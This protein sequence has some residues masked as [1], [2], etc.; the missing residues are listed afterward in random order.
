M[1]SRKSLKPGKAVRGLCALFLGVSAFAAS[2][3]YAGNPIIA[4]QGVND[5]HIHVFGDTAYLYASHDKSPHNT[6]FIMEDWQVWSSEDLVNWRLRSTLLP[7]QT[8]LRSQPDFASAWATDVAE[9]NGKYF[10]Y[11]SEGNHQTGVV[12]GDS[13]VGPWKDVLGAALL[14]KD[15]TPTDEYDPGLFAEADDRYIIFGVW[16]Y[17]MAKLGDDMMSLAETPRRIEIRGARGPYT[18]TSGTPFDGKLTDDKPFLH[19]QGD[20][21]YLSW[22]A[23]YATSKAL[24]GPYQYRGAVITEESFPTGL[25]APTWPTGPQ[26]GR[27]GS[28]FTWHGQTYFAY[29]D[30]SQSG[31]RYFRDTFISYV[32]YRDDGSI[33]PIR[34]D[35]TGVGEYNADHGPIEAEEFFAADAVTKRENAAASNGFDIVLDEGARALT[36]PN[37]RGLAGKDSAVFDIAGDS[38]APFTLSVWRKGAKAPIVEQGFD[39]ANRWRVP[40]GAL[41][42]T[43]SLIVKIERAGRNELALDRISF[44]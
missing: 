30:I 9:K 11:F 13:P 5:P 15:L 16:D 2:E 34:V 12:V 23:F 19:K 43:E 24:Y 17:Y 7:N 14:K 32:H 25:S 42:E 31:N 1:N 40:L 36:F 20:V 44:E 35:E 41:G 22:G 4:N 37:I 39:G 18:F 33:A 26:Q 28:F 10:W 21:Y 29:C 38:D 3:G 8:Y 6:D 27:H